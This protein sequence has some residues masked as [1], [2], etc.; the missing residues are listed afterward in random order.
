MHHR[1]VWREKAHRDH[2]A[3]QTGPFEMRVEESLMRLLDRLFPAKPSSVEANK[4]YVVGQ[5]RGEIS[6]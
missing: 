1:D 2:I 6:A 4:V 3:N 5:I